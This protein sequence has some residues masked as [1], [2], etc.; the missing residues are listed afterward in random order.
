MIGTYRP[1]CVIPARIGS[2]RLPRKNIMALHGQPMLAYTIEAAFDSGLFEQVIVSTEDEE[3]AH[4]ARQFGA[5]AH[6][7]PEELAGDLVS[8]TDVCLQVADVLEAGGRRFESLVCLQPSSPLRHGEDIRT[9]WERYVAADA[10]YLVSVTSV[11][12]H[13]FHWAVH[14]TDQGWGMYFGEQFLMERPLLPPVYRPNG[15]IKIGRIELLRKTRNFFG[16]GLEVSFI[17]EERSV[18]VAEKFD[19]DLAHHLLARPREG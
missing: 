10:D 6:Q 15:A 9:A 17:P 4:V 18:H 7:R 3:I 5:A 2:K 11:D 1:L 19:F 13:Y 14:E 8:A 16:E 12:P